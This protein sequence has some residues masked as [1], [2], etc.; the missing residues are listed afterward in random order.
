MK[1][2]L[3]LFPVHFRRVSPPPTKSGVMAHHLL[4]CAL[5]LLALAAC[6]FAEAAT[7][8]ATLVTE[9][10]APSRVV[11]VSCFSNVDITGDGLERDTATNAHGYC[12][13]AST[14]SNYEVTYSYSVPADEL[15]TGLTVWANAGGLFYDG[16]LRSFDL[17]VDYIDDTGSAATLLM[18]GVNIGDTLN[19]DDP[20][21]VVFMDSGS[22]VALY[23]VTEVRISNLGGNSPEF[24]WREIFA[25]TRLSDNDLQTVKSLTSGNAF[26]SVGDIVTF[27]ITV[28]N[29]GSDD[30]RDTSL[31]DLLPA[32]FTP[33]INNGSATI[34]S[35]NALDGT[36]TIDFLAASSS[37]TLTLEGS[38]DAGQEGNI[39][40]NTTS[41]AD[42]V[43]NDET[44]VVGD[45]LA[46]SV[47]VA[48]FVLTIDKTADRT[49]NLAAGETITYTY[50]VQN[51]GN[52]PISDIAIADTHNGTGSPPI[53]G[54]EILSGDA[55]P[56]GDSTDSGTDGVWDIL[57][58][59][60]EV[61]FTATYLVTQQ[62]IDTLQ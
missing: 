5:C 37:A 55:A 21:S 8:T 47:T 61:T 44:D 58:P 1:P 50:V 54:S 4:L 51:N 60:D 46:A 27:E 26:P 16:E 36:W 18:P 53:P 31:V 39:L 12:P 35:Y 33:T 56:S 52:Q 38:V 34:G 7:L 11:N 14:P 13:L 57:A 2:F 17:E 22:P 43:V 25:E 41:A 24:A 62:D 59:G 19:I 3:V 48:D 10:F 20:K 40:T 6:S 45:T 9:N 29:N 15:M 23:G 32:G 28:F 30:A 42:N 49:S